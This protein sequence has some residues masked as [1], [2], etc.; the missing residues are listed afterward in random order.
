MKLFSYFHFQIVHCKYLEE[1]CFLYIDLASH[2][3]AN[4]FISCNNFLVDSLGFCI[5]TVML[6]ASR[7]SIFPS[8]P[9]QVLFISFSC[10]STLARTSSAMLNRTGERRYPCVIFNLRE[11]GFSLSLLSMML[12]VGLRKCPVSGK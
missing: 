2:D 9:V 11:K 6:F 12:A 3:L 5:H 7:G 1:N 10:P 8:F 4:S